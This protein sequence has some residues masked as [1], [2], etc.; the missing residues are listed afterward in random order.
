M[1]NQLNLLPFAAFIV[2]VGLFFKPL[3]LLGGI[4]AWPCG[5]M[6]ISL[7][8]LYFG[9]VFTEWL[10]G[11]LIRKW[12]ILCGLMAAICFGQKYLFESTPHYPI[13]DHIYWFSRF[14]LSLSWIIYYLSFMFV[15]MIVN[16]PVFVS[17]NNFAEDRSEKAGF[18]SYP[19]RSRKE[20]FWKDFLGGVICFVL[21]M[22]MSIIPYVTEFYTT[23]PKSLILTIRVFS[24][25]P[26][27]AT[28]VYVYKCVMSE[29][30]S[31]FSMKLPKLTR[32]ISGLCPGAIFL[33]LANYSNYGN[34][35]STF[36]ILPILTYILSVL[37][38][39]SLK[40]LS[41][42]CKLLISKEF[43][44]KEVFIGKVF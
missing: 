17:M 8:F 29:K 6:A 34:I 41:G 1:R 35:L 3:S 42:L 25:I 28:I 7:C 14:S 39:F 32:F 38:R 18:L 40:F 9:C 21:Y 5:R 10:Q 37:W 23:A 16:S 44:W 30:M 15:G 27:V 2:I 12:L 26:W 19:F 31:V 22:L 20:R 13:Y 11:K 4:Y 33:I 24:V 36:M 43:G